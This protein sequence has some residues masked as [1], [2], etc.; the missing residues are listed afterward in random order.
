MSSSSV[1]A[2]QRKEGR[3]MSRGKDGREY[4]GMASFPQD[5]LFDMPEPA[6]REKT[7]ACTG[8]TCQVCHRDAE[9]AADK[10]IRRGSHAADP[11][12][13]AAANQIMWDLCASSVE[14]TTDEAMEALEELGVETHDPRALGGVVRRFLNKGLMTEVG[15]TKSR[16]R[17]GARI[18]IYVGSSRH[19]GGTTSKETS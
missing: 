16:R 18:P 17:H 8:I 9:A 3:E 15:T 2:V 12:W 7:H 13:V 19:K 14:F 4:D 6:P 11:A 1:K 5:S 10:A